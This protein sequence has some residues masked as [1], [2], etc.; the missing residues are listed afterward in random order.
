MHNLRQHKLY[1][2]V[3]EKSTSFR[4]MIG[5]DFILLYLSIF[6]YCLFFLQLQYL[7]KLLAVPHLYITRS[8]IF[9]A[10]HAQ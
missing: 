7:S 6:V 10:I 1:W 5:K 4:N 3:I 2:T 9:F 8:S